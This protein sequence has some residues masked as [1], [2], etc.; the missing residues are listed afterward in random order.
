MMK[1]SSIQYNTIRMRAGLTVFLHTITSLLVT[2][3]VVYD[4]ED[5]A[6]PGWE[7]S[8]PERW[9]CS[10]D[11]VLE[12]E[13]SLHHAY[14]NPA[15]GVDYIGRDIRYP[16][17]TDTLAV[18][19]RVRHGYSPSSSNNWQLFI[20]ANSSHDLEPGSES[21][22]GIIMGVNF[23]G[24]D[25]RV[26]VWQLLYGEAVEIISSGL[27]YQE[28]IGTSGE[29]LMKVTRNP[30]GNWSLECSP[31]GTADSM[32]LYGTGRE[33]EPAR[34]KYIGFRYAY[35]S[36]QD[37]KLWMDDLRIRGG[38]FSDTVPPQVID[39]RI[40]G[41]SSLEIRF[42]EDVS[43]PDTSCFSWKSD[44]AQSGTP[45]FEELPDTMHL[46]GRLCQ[47]FFTARF[48]N[49]QQQQLHIGNVSDLEGNIIADTVLLFTQALAEFG[50]VVISELMTDPE[51]RVHLPPCEYVEICNRYEEEIGITGWTIRINNSVYVLDSAELSPGAYLVLT[52]ENCAGQYGSATLQ[53]VIGSMTALTNSGGD[54]ALYDRHGRMIHRVEYEAMERYDRD[55]AEGGWSIERIDSEN[56]CG[57]HENWTASADWKGGTP[58]AENSL[59][60]EVPDLESPLLQYI[61]VPD[62]A[63]VSLT[64]DEY[65]LLQ[66]GED[67]GFTVDGVPARCD[68]GLL[69]AAFRTIELTLKEAIGAGVD[70]ELKISGV[71]DCAGNIVEE[72]QRRF[73]KPEMPRTGVPLVNEIMYDPVQGGSEY[74]EL[75]NP[76]K[77]FL[78]LYDLKLRVTDPGSMEGTL[79]ELSEDSHLLFPGA[80]VVFAKY[81][82]ALREEWGLGP[83]VDV[84]E[85][86]D[87][88]SLPNGG[89]CVQL[90]DRSGAILDQCC[91]HDSLHH[92]LVG[93]TTG[94]ALERIHSGTCA[95]LSQCW[96]SAA[97]SVSYGT[98]GMQNSHSRLPSEPANTLELHPEVFSPDNDG[99]EDL[100]EIRLHVPGENRLVDIFITDL[101]GI[102]VREI[103]FR[104]IP[105]SGDIYS[106]DGIDD[107]GNIV[108]PGIYVVHVGIA[109][110]RGMRFKRQACAIRYR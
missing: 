72:V 87:W 88:R 34:G 29:P 84:V 24:S 82:F 23:T 85:V 9:E 25:D 107:S 35:T 104:G 92:D 31:S 96:T 60:A 57:G 51:P 27:N 86:A 100:L 73:R 70:Y 75:Y 97:A 47:L 61:G 68:F 6:L 56:L 22:S 67:G 28:V 93:V 5:G 55:R 52:H 7:Q 106:W 54:V 91:Y 46:S 95:S 108:L 81:S 110:D 30:D 12:G 98:P 42:S 83:D 58:G 39:Q 1:D 19:F 53:T 33:I 45:G 74:I 62:S 64:F 20:L 80:K 101:N 2:A 50:D 44:A 40:T 89:A 15:A 71:G 78:D 21:S 16:D 18:S 17:L 37:R 10:P 41:L 103:V 48:P 76:G 49:R 66:P 32:V 69:P 65:L 102:R 77:G 94:V 4:F 43:V 14:D 63:R 3:Q 59:V 109:G 38:F 36:A 99:F 79:V 90:T 11:M 26:K 8:P 105:G 13:F